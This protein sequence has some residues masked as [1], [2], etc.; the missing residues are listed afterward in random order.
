MT[1]RIDRDGNPL[2]YIPPDPERVAWKRR[3][4]EIEEHN[5]PILAGIEALE[6]QVT[7]RRMREAAVDP[8]WMKDLDDRIAA[9]RAMI[10]REDDGA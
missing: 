7:P 5:R 8:S 10:R 2:E 3:M 9:L 4:M 1:R 6:S